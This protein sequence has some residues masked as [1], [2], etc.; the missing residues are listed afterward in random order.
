MR[1]P[2]G[3]LREGE[4]R[5]REDVGARPIYDDRVI[6]RHHYDDPGAGPSHA[7]SGRGWGRV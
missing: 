2:R 1:P 5:R 3:E 7:P 4:R 6:Q